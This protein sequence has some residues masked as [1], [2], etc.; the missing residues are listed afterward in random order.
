LLHTDVAIFSKA[1]RKEW[2]FNDC[3]SVE[4]IIMEYP[5]LKE[6][7]LVSNVCDMYFYY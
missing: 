7:K 4:E 1:R 2:I 3:P 5:C 6:Y